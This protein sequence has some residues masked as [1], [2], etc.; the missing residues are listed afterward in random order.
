MS[1]YIGTWENC[2]ESF[3]FVL[4]LMHFKPSLSHSL[5]FFWG[6]LRQFQKALKIFLNFFS[7]FFFFFVFFNLLW[8]AIT[9]QAREQGPATPW[10]TVLECRAKIVSLRN[11]NPAGGGGASTDALDTRQHLGSRLLDNA[12][13]HVRAVYPIARFLGWFYL[14]SSKWPSKAMTFR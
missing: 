4:G 7:F 10:Q 12:R 9:F 11:G 5:F 14:P 6:Y 2:T 13:L 8:G 1:V 3:L